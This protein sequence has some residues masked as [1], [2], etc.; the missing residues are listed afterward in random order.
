[1]QWMNRFS[2]LRL[3]AANAQNQSARVT[4]A[5]GLCN[6][7]SAGKNHASCSWRTCVHGG[8]A[9]MERRTACVAGVHVFMHNIAFAIAWTGGW[10]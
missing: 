2:Q 4:Q 3:V 10:S 6:K 5:V 7:A 8:H 1:M 9:F